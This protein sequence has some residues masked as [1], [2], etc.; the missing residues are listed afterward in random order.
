MPGYKRIAVASTFSPRFHAV[1]AEAVCYANHFGAELEILHASPRDGEKAEHFEA[2]MEKLGRPSRIRWGISGNPADVLIDLVKTNHYDLLIAGA[3]ARE[4]DADHPY[5][6]GV[7]KALMKRCPSDLLFLPHPDEQPVTPRHVV[8]AFT[9]DRPAASFVPTT[10]ELLK[11]A[12]VTLLGIETPFA[13]A[14]A[15]SRGEEP[16]DPEIWIDEMAGKAAAHC[17]TAEGRVVSSITGYSICEVVRGME[18]DLF[19][20]QAR[21]KDGQRKLPLHLD[22][23]NQLIPT[24]LLVVSE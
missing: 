22:W 15:I 1:L 24:R 19:A 6:S 11:P 12:V 21:I 13:A 14:L 7:A 3:L 9:S 2:A 23:L 16:E 10:L 4:N 17:E 5:A 20:V 18:A 8:F